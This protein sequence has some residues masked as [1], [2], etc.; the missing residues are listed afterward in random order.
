MTQIKS[1]LTQMEEALRIDPHALETVSA[2]HPELLYAAAKQV[3]ALTSLRDAAKRNL[4]EVEANVQLSV[5]Q[6]AANADAKIT[7]KSVEACVALDTRVQEAKSKLFDGKRELDQWVALKEAFATRG[8][9]IRDLVELHVANY[10]GSDMERPRT[11]L[12]KVDADYAR[13]Q[14]QIRRRL[15]T[16]K[17]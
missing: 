1:T 16:S 7:E 10:Y 3:A 14:M 5:R 9:A 17:T 13:G 8:Y 2:R 12:R 15:E 11:E 6:Q 4:E